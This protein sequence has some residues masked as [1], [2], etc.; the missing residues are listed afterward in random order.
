M[1]WYLCLTEGFLIEFYLLVQ[2]ELLLSG[3][4][5]VIYLSS[6]AP[7]EIFIVI[8]TNHRSNGL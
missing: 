8:G 4:Y 2:N 5:T 7:L 3:C 6:P 1:E